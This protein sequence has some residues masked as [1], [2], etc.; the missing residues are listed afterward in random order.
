[1]NILKTKYTI[2]SLRNVPNDINLYIENKV[3]EKSESFK[4]LGVMI[5]AKLTFHEHINYLLSK[6]SKSRGIF[7]KLNYLPKN[8]LLTLYYSLVYPYLNYCIEAWGSCSANTLQSLLLIQKKFVRIICGIGYYDPTS[9]AFSRLNI[10]KLNDI[11]LYFT[12]VHFFKILNSDELNFYSDKISSLQIN[13]EHNLRSDSFRLPKVNVYKF[14][15]SAIYQFLDIWNTLP[16]YVTN[17]KTKNHFKKLLKM[18]LIDK[19]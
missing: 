3:L 1:M 14:K 12:S 11:H 16:N 15:Q 9:K 7:Y 2:I 19:Y 8:V 10:L 5:D 13:H 18:Y 17:I 4:F 6:L